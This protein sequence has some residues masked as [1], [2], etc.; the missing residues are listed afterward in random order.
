VPNAGNYASK[1]R[2]SSVAL[3]IDTTLTRCNGQKNRIFLSTMKG[4]WDIV[5]LGKET[6]DSV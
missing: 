3:S 6:E 4:M 2:K 1:A 5:N